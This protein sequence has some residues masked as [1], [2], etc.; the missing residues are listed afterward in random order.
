M[1]HIYPA[2]WSGGSTPSV[3]DDDL[4]I[5]GSCTFSGNRS[6]TADT[7]DV[8]V[9]VDNDAVVNGSS[10]ILELITTSVDREI[11]FNITADDD[12][13]FA[14]GT[15]GFFQIIQRGPG[16]IRWK[17]NGGRS[18]IFRNGS[19]GE[20]DDDGV[21]YFISMENAIDGTVIQ[22]GDN[23][24]LHAAFKILN[25]SMVTFIASTLLADD[26]TE[27]GAFIF[28]TQNT[29]AAGRTYIE[30]GDD[31]G[32]I[33]SGHY[34]TNLTDPTTVAVHLDQPAGLEPIVELKSATNDSAYANMLII[35][36]NINLPELYVDPTRNGL[37]TGDQ[38]GCILGTNSTLR[39]KNNT[40]LDYVGTTTNIDPWSAP[41]SVL[42]NRLSEEILKARNA[43]ALFVDGAPAGTE[44]ALNARILMEENSGIFFRSGA[45]LNGSYTQ[46]SGANFSFLI[47][48]TAQPAGAGNIIFD[49]EGALNILG[50]SDGTNIINIL[51]REVDPT[52][53]LIE[54]G[55]GDAKFPQITFAEDAQGDLLQYAKACMLANNRINLSNMIIR[56]DDFFHEVNATNT[57]QNSEPV[58][59]GGETFKLV[60]SENLSRPKLALYNSSLNLHTSAALTGLDLC[61]TNTTLN[62]VNQSYVRFYQNGRVIDKGTGRALILGT[63]PGSYAYDYATIVD[64]ASY[65]DIQQEV[66]QTAGYTH[67]VDL[68]TAVNDDTVIQ[69]ITGDISTQYSI[70]TLFLGN[71]SNIQ[72]GSQS[73]PSGVTL[74]TLPKLYINGNFFSFMSQGGT[75]GQPE[76]SGTIGQGGIFVDINGTIGIAS[77]ARAHLSMMVTASSSTSVIDLPKN[78]INFG[79]N[80]GVTKWNLNLANEQTIVSVGQSLSDFTIDWKGTSKDYTGGF[81]PFDPVGSL[82]Q[83]VVAANLYHLPEIKGSVDELQIKRSRIGDPVHIMVDGGLIRELVF[84]KGYDSSE[85]PTGLVAIKNNGRIGI[86]NNNTRE[87]SIDAAVVL[88][89]NGVMLVPDGNGVVDL[90]TDIEINNYCHIM[91]GPNFGQSSVQALYIHAENPRILRVKREGVLDLSTFTSD[92]MQLIFSGQVKLVCEPGSKLLLGGGTLLF[93]DKA[94]FCIQNEIESAPST[95]TSVTSTDDFRVPII[96]TGKII[97]NEDAAFVV[98][99]D[100]YVGFEWEDLVG[101]ITSTN[102]TLSIRDNGSLQI[103][104]ERMWGGAFQVGNTVNRSGAVSLTIELDGLNALWAINSQGFFGIGVG[105]V[106]KHESVP[107]NWLVGSLYNV[108]AFNV[109]I[110]QGTIK[111]NN[112]LLGSSDEAALLA[113]GPATYSLSLPSIATDFYAFSALGGGN[114]IRIESG[115]TAVYPVVLTTASSSVGVFSSTDII[116]DN[117][118]ASYVNALA[119]SGTPQNFFNVFKSKEINS[120]ASP[121]AN[122]AQASLGNNQIAYIFNNVINRKRLVR[123]LGSYGDRVSPDDSLRIGAVG[124]NVNKTTGLINNVIQIVR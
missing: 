75:V 69:G 16:A 41:V 90:N 104:T 30:I 29:N 61:V 73:A 113:I 119:A 47:T 109:N 34:V 120:M 92:N 33:V 28:D 37:Y 65:F 44:G 39:L 114:M 48:P 116:R 117:N 82:G 6:I 20:E 95:G 25:N 27:Q 31:A 24:A 68:V 98:E 57:P 96:G 100:S 101:S 52:G 22:R 94:Q 18:V 102:F 107:N 4:L 2:T 13:T 50:D 111:H 15:S 86:G 84:L 5:D 42:Q 62:Q 26:P 32:F 21:R 115:V 17:I 58:Y 72:V 87:D 97:F 79:A 93:T 11:T 49:I 23:S 106:D 19:T 35:N 59:I 103:G 56:H 70:H 55:E 67:Q 99:K 36:K 43:S 89:I 60:T 124:I 123:I 105:I 9:T 112:I 38:S 53:G 85:A 64:A 1:P 78:R 108:A 51:S 121:A 81:I 66:N 45:D 10:H 122:F 46:Q 3:I 88:G 76:L 71:E 77:S 63:D 8:T 14:G 12:L 91:A 7:L 54:I 40:Y 110:T 80:T 118:N 74:T 83:G